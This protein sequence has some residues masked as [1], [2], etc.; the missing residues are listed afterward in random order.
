VRR[1]AIFSYDLTVGGIQKSL[2]NLLRNIDYTQFEVDLYLFLN[3]SFWDVDFPA[4]LHVKYL[5]PL[6]HWQSF[7]PFNWA[8]ARA[9]FDFSGVAPYDLAI[10]F[11][12]Y[13]TSCAVAAVTVPARYRVSWIHNDVELKL[14]DEWKY[15]VLW[16]FFRGKFPYFDEFVGVSQSLIEPFQKM[17]GM[18]E[19]QYSVIPNYID[20]EEIHRKLEE[21]PEDFRVDESCLNF[22]AVG[23]LNHQKGYDIMLDAFSKAAKQRDDLRLYI[24]GGGPERANLE[25]Q[26]SSLGLGRKVTLLGYQQNPF[27]YMKHMD[28]FLSTSRYEGQ[29]MNLMEARV[30]GLPIYCT[31]NLE[32]YCPGIRGSEDLVAALASARKQE[33]H[34]DD[35]GDYNKA[36]QAGICRLAEKAEETA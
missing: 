2:V 11:N 28:A 19:K 35:L 5:N 31:K 33:K 30:V 4:P 10:D 21:E 14:R 27:C 3:N 18:T 25:R 12:S 23:H 36:I 24:M 34:P 32:K 15:R 1:I 7:I 13:Q 6:P 8:K 26:I 17:S 9:S 20:V 29:G 16:H 22:V